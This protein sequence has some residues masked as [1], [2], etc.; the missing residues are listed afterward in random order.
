MPEQKVKT[1]D[2]KSLPD[3]E[4]KEMAY[5]AQERAENA[6]MICQVVKNELARRRS[7]SA[8]NDNKPEALSGD[9]ENQETIQEG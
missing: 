5:D 4:L 3:I 1:I 8:K 7:S 9:T 6:Q 2:I